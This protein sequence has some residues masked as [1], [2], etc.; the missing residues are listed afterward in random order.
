ME[1]NVSIVKGTDYAGIEATT[2]SAIDSEKKLNVH[3]ERH[4]LVSHSD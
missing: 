2:G 4:N 3:I 1:L